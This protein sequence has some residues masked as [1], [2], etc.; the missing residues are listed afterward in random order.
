M[1]RSLG[2]LLQILKLCAAVALT[3]GMHIVYVPNDARRAFGK[4]VAF[5]TTQILLL[6]QASVHVR[7]AVHDERLWLELVAILDQFDGSD[8]ASPSEDILK[9]MTM[10]GSQVVEIKVA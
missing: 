3:K 9:E 6:L 1:S 2:K 7:H 8:F 10:D 5:Q 4:V